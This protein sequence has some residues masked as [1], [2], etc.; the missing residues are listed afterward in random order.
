[1]FMTELSVVVII[2]K[3]EKYL[4]CCLESILNQTYKDFELI[5]VDDGSPDGCPQICDE[6]AKKDRRVRVIHQKNQ[7]SVKARWNGLLAANGKYISLLD[8]DDWIDPNMYSCMI[9]MIKK[10]DSDIA[11][12]GYKEQ[13]GE[14]YIEKRNIIDSGLYDIKDMNIVFTQALYTGK[15]YEPGIIPAFWNKL[16]KRDLFFDNITPPDAIIKMGEDAAVTYP[17]IARAKSIII[18]NEFYPYNYRIID[19]S[20]SR[21]YDAIY[22]ERIEKLLIG[23]KDNLETNKAMMEYLPYYGLFLIKIG[24]IQLFSKTNKDSFRKKIRDLKY[25]AGKIHRIGLSFEQIKWNEF[26]HGD[27]ALLKGF[28][29]KKNIKVISRLYLDKVLRKV[30]SNERRMEA[31]NNNI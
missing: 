25:T 29:D 30:V 8:G 21:T 17:L 13:H 22:F 9:E 15:F 31:K 14:K 19:G 27:R 11:I 7:G 24:I 1:M 2:Y 23:L 20:M 5:L 6:Y 28:V 16:I 10:N 18:N 12:T 26:E 4:R 3:I